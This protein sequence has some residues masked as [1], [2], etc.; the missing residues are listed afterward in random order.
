MIFGRKRIR[1]QDCRQTEVRD[2]GETSCARSGDGDVRNGVDF[3]HSMVESAHESGESFLLITFVNVVLVFLSGQMDELD[4]PRCKSR[5]G[6]QY[7]LFY[8]VSALGSAHDQYGLQAGLEAQIVQRLVSITLPLQTV[9][10]RGPG[11]FN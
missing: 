1:N 11:H 7:R 3:F 10:N 6:R 5:Q 2:L 4:R 9:A 8:S